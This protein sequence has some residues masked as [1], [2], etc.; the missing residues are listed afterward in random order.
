M[1]E[2]L[3]QKLIKVGLLLLAVLIIWG[4]VQY[5]AY[6]FTVSVIAFYHV[7]KIPTYWNNYIGKE[8]REFIDHLARIQADEKHYKVELKQRFGYKL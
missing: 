6:W 8:R 3:K 4:T 7:T 1:I 5:Q 2:L